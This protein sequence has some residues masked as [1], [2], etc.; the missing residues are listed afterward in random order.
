MMSKSKVVEVAEGGRH[1]F[2]VKAAAAGVVVV[3]AV[4]VTVKAAMKGSQMAGC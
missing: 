1:K 3:T 2:V 4:M